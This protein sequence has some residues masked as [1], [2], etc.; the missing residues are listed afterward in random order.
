M[1]GRR[2]NILIYGIKDFVCRLQLLSQQCLD[3]YCC[4]R[5]YLYQQMEQVEIIREAIKEVEREV[6]V[7]ERH[8]KSSQLKLQYLQSQLQELH[9]AGVRGLGHIS[10]TNNNQGSLT[11]LGVGR[12]KLKYK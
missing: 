9:I 3:I 6:D 2:K 12:R 11:Y 5:T 8:L 1:I 7:A 10:D 4:S